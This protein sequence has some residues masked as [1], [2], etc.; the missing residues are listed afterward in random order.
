MHLAINLDHAVGNLNFNLHFLFEVKSANACRHRNIPLQYVRHL[1]FELKKGLI[2]IWYNDKVDFE[3][4]KYK[5]AHSIAILDLKII[6]QNRLS[7]EN[8]TQ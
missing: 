6:F 8:M 4:V 5:T 2:P 1:D 7:V 3:C